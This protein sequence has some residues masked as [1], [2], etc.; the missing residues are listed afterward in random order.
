MPHLGEVTGAWLAG[1]FDND[2][3]VSTFAI[4]SLSDSFDAAKLNKLLEIYHENILSYYKTVLFQETVNSLS[5]ERSV[6]PD[7]AKAKFALVISSAVLAIAHLISTQNLSD[8][9]CSILMTYR[10]LEQ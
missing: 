9:L 5:D 2:K 7:D 3:M 1:R 4:R 6:P 8:A 10:H